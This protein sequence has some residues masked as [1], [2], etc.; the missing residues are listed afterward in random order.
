MKRILWPVILCFQ[1]T[2]LGCHQR[3]GSIRE[4]EA[5]NPSQQ[6]VAESQIPAPSTDTSSESP[7]AHTGMV[8]IKGGS[9]LM[10]ASDGMPYEGPVHEINLNPYW[11][12]MHEVTVAEF[13]RFIAA[14]GYQTDAEKYGWSGMFDADAG[15]WRKMPAAD[16][17][18]PEGPAHEIDP[19]EPVTQISWNDATAY[20]AWAKKRLP[21]EA[22][23]EYAARGGLAEK[24]YAWGE[25]LKPGGKYLANW[26]QGVFPT[27]Q[28][29][30]DGYLRRAVVGKF[31]P[32]G[33]GLYD[34]AGNVWEWCADWFDMS[35]YQTSPRHNPQGPAAGKEKVIRGGSWMCS[36]NY[37]QGFR[38]AARS[39]A[40]TDTGLNNLG[41][42]CVQDD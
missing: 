23:W 34:M 8:L 1:M 12:D 24:K 25:D 21:T 29:G 33:Y 15:E 41:F 32:N 27:Q 9:F 40:S 31:P 6:A 20:A 28:T 30:E 14:T 19:Q 35:Y 10:G 18:H 36:E 7:T 26:W 37:C 39:H 42:R 5:S 3:A 11:I 16:W 22:E 38:V 4:T 17:R 2:W 13:A